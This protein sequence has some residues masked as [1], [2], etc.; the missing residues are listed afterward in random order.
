MA[1]TAVKQRADATRNRERIMAAAREVL[2]EYGA[3]APLD[4]VA[5]RAG[6]GNATVYRHFAD[7]QELA[8]QVAHSVMNRIADRAERLLVEEPD[9]F[10]ALRAFVHEA[11]DERVGALCPMLVASFGK[12]DPRL[13]EGRVRLHEA[14]TGLMEAARRSGR[15]RDDIDVGDLMVA[16]SQLTRPLPGSHCDM[17]RFIHRHLQLFVDGLETPARSVLPGSSVTLEDLRGLD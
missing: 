17:G 1:Q 3:D 2:L 8:I 4:E 16:I 10:D 6:V 14:V 5:R 7:R 11:A 15:L 13:E 9:P 12:G